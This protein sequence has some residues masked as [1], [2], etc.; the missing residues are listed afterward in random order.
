MDEILQLRLLSGA[1]N[2]GIEWVPVLALI[3]I[4]AIYVVVPAVG[5]QFRRPGMLMA[6]LYLLIAQISVSLLHL[7][8]LYLSALDLKFARDRS[9]I[10]SLFGFGLL[11]MLLFV[12]AMTMFVTG[13]RSLKAGDR[14]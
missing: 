9:V 14:E 12:C 8:W 7:L 5:Y 4:S 11:K 6:S 2:G 3:A 1:Y 13:L 10:H